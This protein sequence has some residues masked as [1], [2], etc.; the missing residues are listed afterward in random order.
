MTD[1]PFTVFSCIG[2]FLC[3]PPAY[4]NWK[5][6]GRPWATLI[7]IGWIC[8]F[9][10]LSFIDSIIWSGPD[11]AEWWD[12]KIYCDIFSRVNP[13]SKSVSPLL[14]LAF[15]DSWQTQRIPTR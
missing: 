2:F 15:V 7:F 5:I 4:F 8:V 14:E 1:I 11:P 3:L 9:N 10:G 13:F 12:G 6:P